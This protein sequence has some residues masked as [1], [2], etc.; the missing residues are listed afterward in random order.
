[1]RSVRQDP[2]RPDVRILHC[3]KLL[4]QDLSESGLEEARPQGEVLNPH[5]EDETRCGPCLE[6]ALAARGSSRRSEPGGVLRES[7]LGVR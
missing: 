5:G 2:R 3:D 7:T 6:N 4:Q 1:M